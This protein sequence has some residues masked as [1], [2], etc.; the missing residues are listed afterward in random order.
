MSSNV[1]NLSQVAQGPINTESLLLEETLNAA[2]MDLTVSQGVAAPA[3]AS[4]QAEMIS[5]MEVGC[6]TQLMP[7][8]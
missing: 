5:R 6:V 2:A 8:P 4:K 7:F 3:Q 1:S